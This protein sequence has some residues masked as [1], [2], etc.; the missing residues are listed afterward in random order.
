M[1]KE[2]LHKFRSAD[3]VKKYIYA[4][5]IVFIFFVL[6]GVFSALMNRTGVG[7]DIERCFELPAS[8]ALLL[9]RPWTLVTYMFMHDG[10]MHILWNMLALH[11]FG[12]IFLN[13]FSARHFI[14]TYLLGGLFGALF[15][16]AAYN[17]FPLFSSHVGASFL[18][19]ASASVL[20]V[21]TA[22]AVRCPENRIARELIR[23]SGKPIAAPSANLSGSPSPTSAEH[24]IKDMSGR[25]DMIIDGGDCDFGLESTIVKLDDDGGI[26]LLRPG[27]ITVSDLEAVGFRVEVASAVMNKLEEGKVALS[28]GMKYRH[29]AP[30][31]DV[32]LLKG[33]LEKSL[34]YIRSYSAAKKAVIAYTEDIS[35]YQSHIPEAQIYDFG[36][37]ED[38]GAQAHSLF[39][40]LRDAD[41]CDFDVIFAPLPDADG[42][43]LALYNR[44]I[45][46]AA[47][48][49]IEL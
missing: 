1:F 43:G 44:M 39:R 20:A 46:A 9:Q 37:R 33:D 36:S 7:G 14:G 23:L 29:Y 13:F 6:I 5:V 10:I 3:V 34:S 40:I 27:K 42:I 49:I 19:G 32:L 30:K 12:K 47:Y 22:V 41:K 45:R 26:T 4:N 18:V 21:I 11:V 25:C 24:V 48:K 16:V 38:M 31:A 35:A 28:P 17:V 2:L 8:L 15:Y